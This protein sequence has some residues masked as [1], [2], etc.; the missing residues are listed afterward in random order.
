[1][2]KNCAKIFPSTEQEAVFVSATQRVG[3]AACKVTVVCTIQLE[4]R[5]LRHQDNMSP[6]IPCHLRQHL[7]LTTYHL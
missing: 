3:A 7:Y 5:P 2:Y 4:H 6:G 1:M